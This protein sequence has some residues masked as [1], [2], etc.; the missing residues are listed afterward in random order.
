MVQL[1]ANSDFET[2]VKIDDSLFL[3]RDIKASS[4][5][6]MIIKIRKV[7]VITFRKYVL[8]VVNIVFVF[9]NLF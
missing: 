9:F 4:S 3:A 6:M 7:L 8:F 2:R 5:V 1:N